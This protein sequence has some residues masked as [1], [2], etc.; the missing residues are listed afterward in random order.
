MSAMS[1]GMTDISF[2]LGLV[3]GTMTIH[4]CPHSLY[5]TLFLWA[6]KGEQVV[7]F[8]QFPQYERKKQTVQNMLL[9]L[10]YIP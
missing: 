7:I 8:S 5:V 3:S 4:L 9:L 10:S 6:L 1:Q 2:Y